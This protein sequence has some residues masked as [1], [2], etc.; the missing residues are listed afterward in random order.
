MTNRPP[1]RKNNSNKADPWAELDHATKRPG[2]NFRPNPQT[3]LDQWE[4][5]PPKAM[6]E[7]SHVHNLVERLKDFFGLDGEK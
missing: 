3:T 1:P 4:P 7:T 6:A 2:L 5:H